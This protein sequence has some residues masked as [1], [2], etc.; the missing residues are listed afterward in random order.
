ML[1]FSVGDI[2]RLRKSHP[3]GGDQW[4]IMRVGMDFRLKCRK[5]GHQVMTPRVKFEKSFKA[6]VKSSLSDEK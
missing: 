5:C 2:V 6:I 1:K 3:C 4:E